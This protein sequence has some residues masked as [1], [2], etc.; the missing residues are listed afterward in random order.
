MARSRRIAIALA[1]VLAGCAGKSHDS[2]SGGNPVSAPTTKEVVAGQVSAALTRA[3]SCDDLLSLIQD[4]VSAKLTLQAELMRQGDQSQNGGGVS[5]GINFASSAP[6]AGPERSAA[7]TSGNASAPASGASFGGTPSSAG[8]APAGS[9]PAGSAP[10]S[11]GTTPSNA[12]LP[13]GT[14]TAAPAPITPSTNGASQSTA[15]NPG[16]AT[17]G[18]AGHSDTNVQVQGVDEADIVKID[19][20][21]THIYVLH[22]N[23]L[24]VLSSWPADQT[25]VTGTLALEGSATEMFVQDGMVA[26]FSNVFDEGDLVDAPPPSTT[27]DTTGMVAPAY[28]YYGSAFT[29]ITLI[30]VDSDKPQVARE[31]FIEGNYLSARRY[32][33]TVRAVIQGG[34]RTPQIYAAQIDYTDPWGRKYSQDEI[35]S[36]VNA[37]LDR[38][39]AAVKTTKL[40]DWLPVEREVMNG[41]LGAPARRCT[42]FYAPSPGLSDYGL[43]NVVSFDMTDPK[44]ALGGAIVLG[45]ADQ[46]YSNESVLLLAHLD[47]RFDSG[48]IERERTVLHRFDLKGADTTYSASGLAPGH[49]V[50]QFS[51]DEQAG[52]VRVATTARLIQNFVPPI[53]EL[54]M[55][56][57]KQDALP[58]ASGVATLA[59]T[60]DSRVSTLKVDGG[61]LVRIGITDPLGAD[62]ETLK[63]SRFVGDRGYV[64]TFHNTDPLMVIDLS[65]PDTLVKLGELD[66]PGFSDYMHPLDNDHLL[67]IGRDTDPTTGAD[68]GLMLQLFDV[69]DPTAPRRSNTYKFNPNGYSAA[70]DNHKAFT[71]YKPAG[72]MGYDGLLAF[73]YVSYGYPFQSTLEV[74]QV[75][76]DKGFT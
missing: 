8:S 55:T 14:G 35:D 25:A 16:V 51:L 64:V 27:P 48:L 38:M 37:W 17:L 12:G 75:A 4:D 21:G 1:S 73:P 66:I 23:Q 58:D 15:T 61:K 42:D 7:D 40:S 36:Q 22:G 54:A 11:A 26:V 39:I 70:N 19:A 59:R 52:I 56:A 10:A 28:Q 31:L 24:V 5:K 34:F 47:Y 71:Y 74:F 72:A 53:L 50:D 69:S 45:N 13:G 46:V 29:K 49:I 30:K 20:D 41:K 65:K 32:D 9:S 76:L 62:G 68:R 57:T 60:T 44:S 43:T 18:P 6:T 67:T 2:A 33:K 3:S 63:S